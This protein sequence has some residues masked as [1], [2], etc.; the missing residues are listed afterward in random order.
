MY[1]KLSSKVLS[2]EHKIR[3]SIKYLCLQNTQRKQLSRVLTIP[4]NL[5]CAL[6][7]ISQAVQ[8]LSSV[9][10]DCQVII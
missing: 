6:S 7:Q 1:E 8:M 5:V 9:T 10:P 4:E 2:D 3:L